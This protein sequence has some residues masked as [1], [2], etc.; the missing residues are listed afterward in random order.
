MAAELVANLAR[1]DYPRDWLQVL[2]V[3]EV[4]DHETQAAFGALDLPAGFQV[5]V[6]PPGSPETKSR[7]CNVALERAHGDLVVIYDAEDAPHP[8]QLREAAARFAPGRRRPRLLA[9]SV[10][11]RA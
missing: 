4:D 5:L 7:A 11:D 8:G 6:A 2:I 9:G 10:A 3:L 1:L